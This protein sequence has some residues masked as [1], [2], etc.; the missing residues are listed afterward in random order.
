MASLIGE[1]VGCLVE[2]FLV[3]RDDCG[4]GRGEGGGATCIIFNNHI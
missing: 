1:G 3:G 2:Q 4:L